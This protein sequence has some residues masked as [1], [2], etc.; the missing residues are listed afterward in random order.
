[1]IFF[2]QSD[3][4]IFLFYVMCE[5]DEHGAHPVGYFS[6]EKMNPNA[7]K[8]TNGYARNLACIL[9]F[10]AYQKRGYGKF[11]ISFSYELSKIENIVGEP[12]RPIS[13]L[14]WLSYLGY[15]KRTLLKIL[16]DWEGS[17]SIAE[18][19]DMTKITPEFIIRTLQELNM[20]Q[21][22]K[23]Q[24]VICAAPDLIEYHL[25]KAGSPGLLV[26]SSKIVWSPYI[27]SD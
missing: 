14:G 26:E 1:M 22:V 7:K 20:I 18:L 21:Y 8:N 23:G 24:H 2:S 4:D 12:E 15:W 3:V 25:Q 9:T 13:D 16:K 27:P 11:L 10:P 19:S 5:C 17:I 6:K